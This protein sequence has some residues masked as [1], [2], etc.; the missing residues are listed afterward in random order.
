M[1]AIR[2]ARGST[3]WADRPRAAQDA[4]ADMMVRNPGSV[5]PKCRVNGSARPCDALLPK[6]T[7]PGIHISSSDQSFRYQGP[8]R[9]SRLRRLCPVRRRACIVAFCKFVLSSAR[10]HG[11]ADAGGLP[12]SAESIR[13]V[14]IAVT[15]PRCA[16]NCGY[17][18][19]QYVAHGLQAS[20]WNR[21]G[22]AQGARRCARR[23]T[24][25]GNRAR[26]PSR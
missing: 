7:I 12:L 2:H 5:I 24:R 4:G 3:R 13:A 15:N 19:R 16:W 23:G 8:S 18:L 14:L 6:G 20:G 9:K 11:S 26:R 17:R 25:S 1:Q 10:A 22:W 21:N